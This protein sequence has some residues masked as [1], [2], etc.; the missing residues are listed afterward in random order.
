VLLAESLVT[1]HNAE[2]YGRV[3]R[4]LH[5]RRHLIAL[6]DDL[7]SLSRD[8]D[9]ATSTTVAEIAER[10]AEL[11]ATAA[12]QLL[13]GVEPT[14]LVDVQVPQRQW[15]VPD[16][17]PLARA[18]ALYG[19]GGEGKTLLAQ[20][21]ATACAIGEPWLGMPVIKCNSL[22]LFC[23]DDL[24][25]MHRR[26]EAINSLYGCTFADLGA[27]LWLPRLGDDN[28]LMS[29]ETGRAIHTPLFGELLATAKAHDARL[30]I[31]DTLAD[32]FAG[33]ENDRGQARAFTQQAL[34]YLARETRGAAL[35]LAHP[36]RAGMNSG[37]GESGSTAWVG[38][39]RSQLYLATLKADN[40]SEP[41]EP[42][43]RTLT[44]HKS[45]A[46]RRGDEIEL[47]WNDGVL[48]PTR[49]A[50][51]IGGW[52]ER[53]T[54]KRVFLDLLDRVKAEGRY[55]S[56]NSHSGSYAPTAFARRPDREGFRVGDFK[57]A[58]EELFVEREIAMGEY[59]T[60]G[61]KSIPCIV[62]AP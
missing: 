14:S 51:G 11:R 47:R 31:T 15:L 38:T 56:S 29:F 4:N 53:K 43:L 28:A 44:R 20:Q 7:Q 24:D 10:M 42:D 45:N 36:S 18:T 12:P 61:R 39:F 59:R 48:V 9:R 22:L 33:N 40:Q 50:T 52:V 16:W 57:R 17:V 49:Q 27:M 13:K 26:Q 5:E 21:L 1:P 35:A 3:I 34:G 58:M 41:A 6:G 37:S 32:I 2:Y 55:V 25:E 19:A 60:A 46:A 23:E 8:F 30:V 54:A 62:R